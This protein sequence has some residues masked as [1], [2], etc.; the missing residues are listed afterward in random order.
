[1]RFPDEEQADGA[2]AQKTASFGLT[3]RA[4]K[5]ARLYAEN[6]GWTITRVAREAGFSDRARGAHVPRLRTHA[7]P[8]RDPGNSPFRLFGSQQGSG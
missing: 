7:G 5:F 4:F 8:A 1:M 3:K 2:R 6:P